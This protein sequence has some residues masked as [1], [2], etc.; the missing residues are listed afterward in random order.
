MFKH[1]CESPSSQLLTG[2][3]IDAELSLQECLWGSVRIQQR[4]FVETMV[5]R[6]SVLCPWLFKMG[7]VS[8]VRNHCVNN[9]FKFFFLGPWWLVGLWDSRKGE[10]DDRWVG[11]I[12]TSCC[13]VWREGSSWGQ[14]QN[15]QQQHSQS[16]LCKRSEASGSQLSFK[17]TCCTRIFGKHICTG[18][19][20]LILLCLTWIFRF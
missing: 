20:P 12:R 10:G 3:L 2:H 13:M 5:Y 18:A 7:P 1:N 11:G 16:W 4:C 6:K 9:F 8:L 15:T 14:T 19:L 17:S